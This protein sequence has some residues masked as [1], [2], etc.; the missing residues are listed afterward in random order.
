MDS[1]IGT[2]INSTVS[3]RRV[4]EKHRAVTKNDGGRDG[5]RRGQVI[6]GGNTGEAREAHPICVCLSLNGAQQLDNKFEPRVLIDEHIVTQVIVTQHSVLCVMICCVIG[7]MLYVLCY[8][9]CYDVRYVVLCA[10]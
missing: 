2:S 8:A 1:A 10:I 5:E 3:H 4:T 7:A 6:R 9:M